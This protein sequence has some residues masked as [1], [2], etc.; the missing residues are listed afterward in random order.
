MVHTHSRPCNWRLLFQTRSC[1]QR[2]PTQGN[3]GLVVSAASSGKA[4]HPYRT[5]E[6]QVVSNPTLPEIWKL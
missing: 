4:E 1:T 6:A 5:T 2:D 3:H